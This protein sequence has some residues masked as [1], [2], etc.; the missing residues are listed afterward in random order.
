LRPKAAAE[1][2]TRKP[3]ATHLPMTIHGHHRA[4]KRPRCLSALD[5][6]ASCAGLHRVRRTKLHR[7]GARGRQASAMRLRAGRA[8]GGGRGSDFRP[9]P[10]RR[11]IPTLRG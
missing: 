3:I 10:W 1:V 7:D 11:C 6:V 8:I 4:A 9:V 2:I 5:M